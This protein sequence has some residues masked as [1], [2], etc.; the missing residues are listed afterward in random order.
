LETIQETENVKAS[1]R[2]SKS[3]KTNDKDSDHEDTDVEEDDPIE[4]SKSSN[5]LQDL[6]QKTSGDKFI[7][8]LEVE[9]QLKLLWT[10]HT[11]ILDF[12]FSRSVNNG[13]P[14]PEPN[15]DGYRLFFRRVIM[16]PPNKFRPAGKIGDM[17][18]AHPQNVHLSK[19]IEANERLRR[20]LRESSTGS[21]D[22]HSSA[23]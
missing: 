2:N 6:K 3:T 7:V 12:I 4:T 10:K 20:C 16:V 14:N 23:L 19:I 15:L 5:S 8:P 21:S 22:N 9:A 18:V 13:V 1:Q 11:D 17:I